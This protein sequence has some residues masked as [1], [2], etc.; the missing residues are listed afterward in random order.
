MTAKRKDPRYLLIYV[1]YP[2]KSIQNATD[3]TISELG[4][5]EEVE[6]KYFIVPMTGTLE[7]ALSEYVEKYQIPLNGAKTLA[8]HFKVEVEAIRRKTYKRTP[9]DRAHLRKQMVSANILPSTLATIDEIVSERNC[10]RS[11]VVAELIEL[12]LK[13]REILSKK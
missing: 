1:G 7:D 6:K 10:S 12:G 5:R 4:G 2:S 3:A 13:Y 8:R 11:I 9:S